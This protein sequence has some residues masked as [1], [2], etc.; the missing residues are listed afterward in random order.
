M[1]EEAGGKDTKERLLEAACEMF[2]QKGYTDCSVAEIT[3]LAGANK[4]AINY[5]FGS[6][7]KL[8]QKAWRKEFTE[9][10]KKY[11]VDGGVAQNA[12]AAERLRGHIQSFFRRVA[13]PQNREFDIV[14]NNKSDVEMILREVMKKSLDPV[15]EHLEGIVREI[16]G[17]KVALKDIKLCCLSIKSQCIDIGLNKKP[18]QQV[19]HRPP[20]EGDIEEIAEHIF[21]FSY[22][23]ILQL[24]KR[25]EKETD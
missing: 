22:A 4:A 24:R 13:D 14:K 15:R 18:T 11:P 12:P 5:Y 1:Q 16:A 6:K 19:S 21:N 17:S 23:G 3:G 25:A 7:E 8:Y 10:I 20:V 2:A 9:A